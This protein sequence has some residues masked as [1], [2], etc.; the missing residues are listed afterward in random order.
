MD[1]HETIERIGELLPAQGPISV[2]IHHNC[3]HAFEEQPFEQAV[4]TAA[5][6]FDGEPFL[7]EEVYRAA[8][9]TGRM[10][11][12]DL[13]EA[14]SQGVSEAEH[15]IANLVERATFRFT[16]ARHGVNHVRGQPLVWMLHELDVLRDSQTRALW[17]ACLAAVARTDAGPVDPP[18]PPVRHRDFVRAAT[19]IDTDTW[20]DPI[21]IRFVGAYLDQGL[22][23]RTLAD[24]DRGLYALFVDTYSRP[25]AKFCAPWANALRTLLEEEAAT[26][27]DPQASIENS[28]AELRVQPAEAFDFLLETALALRGW[29]GMVRQ[30]EERPD[31][32]PVQPV[33]ARLE[34]YLAVRLLLER[35]A[36][37]YA[38]PGVADVRATLRPDLPIS[39]PPTNEERAWPIFQL[40]RLLALDPLQ[41]EPLTSTEV[42]ELEREFREFDPLERRRVLHRAFE[43]QLRH[44]FYDAMAQTTAEPVGQP[45]VQAVFCVDE[46]EESF[47]R[48]LEEV[49]PGIETFST[50]GFFGV[51][52]YFKGATDGRPRPLAPIVIRPEHYV[53]A[54]RVTSTVESWSDRVAALRAQE[55]H[56]GSRR[57]F[58]GL[59]V[60][61]MGTVALLPLI[62]RVLFPRLARHLGLGSG[63]KQAGKLQIDRTD[64]RPPLGRFRGYTVDE[65]ADIV[66]RL[67][68]D[69]GMSRRPLAPIVLIIGHASDSL[70]NPHRSAYDCGACGGGPGGPNARAAA[71]M[72]ND[73]RVRT[74]LTA[75][76]IDIPA[77]TWFIG[78]QHNSADDTVEFFDVDLLPAGRQADLVRVRRIVREAAQRNAQ[79]RCRHFANVPALSPPGALSHVAGRRRDLAEPRP[80]Y[81]HATNAFCVIGPRSLTR[82]LFLDRR[83]FLASY[84][85]AQ[86]DERASI[87]A[88]IMGAVIPVV[89]GINLEYFFGTVD[90]NC[91]G[92]GTKLPHNVTGLIGVMNGA[93]SDLRTGLW[94]Q[95]VEIHEPVR[96]SI[97]IVANRAAIEHVIEE[98]PGL[99]R[100]VRNGWVFLAALEPGSHELWERTDA[101]FVPY[102]PGR[103]LISIAGPSDRWFAGKRGLLSIVRLTRPNPEAA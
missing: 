79:E 29:A 39:P 15:R 41:I 14:I 94:K 60:S 48:H 90:N 26:G 91:Y 87:L 32:V 78:G 24:R 50:A 40:A 95:T 23:L 42:A 18:K 1:L 52:M 17:N 81:N 53:E 13:R 68:V 21:L 9:A 6:L 62:L 92:S 70:N 97:V 10:T 55:V 100:I 82:G 27:R 93:Q 28:L 34:D 44:R 59:L 20:I 83:T 38:M 103:P 36:L 30:I 80:E 37:A 96:L 43:R 101:G 58:R 31:R 84:D 69:T 86:D 64:E 102:T 75:R 61:L 65:M 47:R 12:E 67:L 71:M 25:L 3:L 11:D 99:A 85:P 33:P 72:A 88:R 35:A 57:L 5:R 54:T 56:L 77:S 74:L 76:R 22:A 63:N 4:I 7:T 16:V 98:N 73:P 45:E 51:A 46:R 8:F 2:F 49:D 89:A 19:G 66:A